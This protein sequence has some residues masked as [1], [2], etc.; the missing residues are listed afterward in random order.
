MIRW[1]KRQLST[2]ILFLAVAWVW[3][4]SFV[5]IEVGLHSFPPL[6]FA[7]LRYLVAGLL[8][9]CVAVA[10]GRFRPRGRREWGAVGLVGVLVVAAYNGLLFIGGGSVGGSVAAVVVS[11][12]PVL[13]GV[14]A[15]AL[16]PDE[17]FT[18]TDAAGLLL[19]V[20]G[21]VVIA[22]PGGGAV[23]VGGVALVF[24]GVVAFAL[25]SVGLR[26]LDPDLPAP[27]LQGWSMLVGA[28]LLG[29]A[30]V[31]RGKPAPGVPSSTPALLSFAYLSVVAG[32]LGYLAYFA[33]LDRVGPVRVNLVAYLEPVTA[34][35]VAWGVLGDAPT[36][37]M[38]A[39]F[40]LVLGGFA[41]T[42]LSDPVGSVR[43][44]VVRS[45][46]AGD[47]S[48]ANPRRNPKPNPNPNR[49]AERRGGYDGQ[50]G[51]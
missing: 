2:A 9:S 19:G 27:A 30:A 1:S 13:T 42:T 31:V 47:E 41:L 33:L 14:A 40:C 4:G 29:G 6:W 36:P 12:S 49:A 48:P 28:A 23:S 8:V 3:G 32:A 51:D 24:A 26:A 16:L 17:G 22:D 38:A 34:A 35:L 39:G 5:A 50:P 11:L 15:G 10:T 37:T 46:L 21:V 7:G 25:G 45:L 43:S 20:G 18:A 44:H